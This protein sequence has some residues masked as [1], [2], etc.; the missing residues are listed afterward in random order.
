[1]PE[2]YELFALP[3]SKES[4]EMVGYA[5]YL[6]PTG[7]DGYFSQVLYGADT[8]LR[9]FSI[10]YDTLSGESAR[11]TVTIDGVEMT[12]ARYIRDLFQRQK[13]DGRPFRILSPETNNYYLARFDESEQSI[14]KKLQASYATQVNL[15]QVR[16]PGVTVFDPGQMDGVLTW[17]DA[18]QIAGATDG[19]P[20]PAGSW[21]DASDNGFDFST[22][23]STLWFEGIQNDLP[24][25]RLDGAASVLTS[26][27]ASA[28]IS[29]VFIVMKMREN[30]FSNIAGILTDQNT[31]A[32]LVGENGL[33]TFYDFSATFDY[34]TYRKNGIEYAQDNQQAPMNQ[35]GLVHVRATTPITFASAIQIGKDRNIAA[36]WA[37]ADIAE[38]IIFDELQPLSTSRELASHLMDKWDI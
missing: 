9:R 20:L 15:I 7:P 13:V 31:L 24:V 21:P 32:I 28:I 2:E 29:E 3:C 4:T 33:T 37:D 30:T 35:F 10:P 19:D 1:M 22:G 16:I 11:G 38:V 8:G 36:R 27:A 6:N 25:V 23:A 12:R 5:E 17:L 26:G 18:N 14:T 34:L